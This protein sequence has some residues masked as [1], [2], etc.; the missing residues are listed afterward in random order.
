MPMLRRIY[1]QGPSKALNLKPDNMKIPYT[2]LKTKIKRYTLNKWQQLWN[3]N[4]NNKLYQ[5]KPTLGEWEP[6]LRK[7]RKEQVVTSRLRI[8]H[9]DLTH[10]FILKQEPP[11]QC[12]ACQTQFTIK[13]LL[14]ECIDLAT[15]RKLF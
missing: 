1:L 11:P 15:T 10:S 5:I 2:D 3:T 6:G 4:T 13:H 9:S 7:S 12:I 8:G 14:T